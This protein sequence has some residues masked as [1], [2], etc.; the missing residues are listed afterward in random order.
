MRSANIIAASFLLLLVIFPMP[1]GHSASVLDS[2]HN[3]SVAST[4]SIKSTTEERIC[5]FCHTPHHATLISDPNYPGPLWSREENFNVYTIYDSSTVISRSGQP[6]GPSRLCLSCHDGTIAL[7]SPGTA[8]T[9]GALASYST[10]AVLGQD[11]SDDHPISMEYGANPQEFHDP[12]L[13]RQSRINLYYRNGVMNVECTSCHDPHDNQY[14]NF[15]VMDTA[16]QTDALCTACHNKDGWSGSD[17]QSGGSRYS[18]AVP[19]AVEKNGCVNCHVSHGAEQGE[20]LLQLSAVGASLD[21]NCVTTCHN[22]VSPYSDIPGQF[23]RTYSHPLDYD[24]GATAHTANELLPLAT[25]RKH[26]HCVDCHNPHQARWQDAPLDAINA[27]AVNGVLKGARG[28]A[29]N[30]EMIVPAIYEYQVCFGC[31]S[32]NDARNGDFN[33]SILRVRRIYNSQD[34]SER[35]DPATAGS[36][37]PVATA[38]TGTGASLRAT[39]KTDYIYC[40]SCHQPH[41]SSEPHLLRAANPD[42]FPNLQGTDFPLCYGCHNDV[43]LLNS[44]PSATLHNNHVSGSHPSGNSDRVPC[45]ACHDPHGVPFISGQSNGDRSRLINFDRRYVPET[46]VY[47]A[48][49]SPSCSITGP[50]TDGLVCHP[51]SVTNP[52]TY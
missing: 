39:A 46:A 19:A 14:G 25:A 2:P 23:N 1:S 47:S 36:Y 18:G 12:A 17:H 20:S 4:A 45:S 21:S 22:G 26:V 42:L 49:P 52:A 28:V 5:I 13:L 44:S 43:Y 16:L 32:G 7:S 10:S 6:Q 11:L 38:T 9:M 29:M 40:N 51:A 3:L 30:G 41:G 31:H 15:S 37:H 8:T 35:F 27:P 24:G 33:D 34:L 48:T 50:G